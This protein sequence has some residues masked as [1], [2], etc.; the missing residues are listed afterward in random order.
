MLASQ[1]C[2]ICFPSAKSQ[3]LTIRSAPL[4]QMKQ[5]VF[6]TMTLL[7]TNKNRVAVPDE[8][9]DFLVEQYKPKNSVQ[10]FLNVRY[11]YLILLL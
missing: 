10:A 9:F 8:R 4:N 1:R 6:M 11:R 5:S 7:E 3:L 2:S